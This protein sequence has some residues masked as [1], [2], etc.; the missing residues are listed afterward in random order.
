M[1][2][3][4]RGDQGSDGQGEVSDDAKAVPVQQHQ[5][6]LAGDRLKHEHEHNTWGITAVRARHVAAVAVNVGG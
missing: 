6:C 3:Q 5:V 4:A 1:V 2:V